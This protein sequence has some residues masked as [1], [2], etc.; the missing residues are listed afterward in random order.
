MSAILNSSNT[1][2]RKKSALSVPKVLIVGV[3]LACNLV[4]AAAGLMLGA[5][6]S[7]GSQSPLPVSR[8]GTGASGLSNNSVFIG[9]GINPITPRPWTNDVTSGS[10]A[11]ITSGAVTSKIGN[12]VFSKYDILTPSGYFHMEWGGASNPMVR[13]VGDIMVISGPFAVQVQIPQSTAGNPG[14]EIFSIRSDLR[15]PENMAV[16]C[17]NNFFGVMETAGVSCTYSDGKVWVQTNKAIPT[18]RY[19]DLNF[20]YMLA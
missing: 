15:P 8:G 7:A 9:N 1:D 17:S 2:N 10:N 19:I 3:L 18:G 4:C 13:R 6:F 11:I 14:V 16:S 20:I 5:S 12:A